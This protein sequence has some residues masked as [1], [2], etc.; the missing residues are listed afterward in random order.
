MYAIIEDKSTPTT[1][2]FKLDN[3][4]NITSIVVINIA[5][6]KEVTI[7]NPSDTNITAVY[8]D[9]GLMLIGSGGKI[10]EVKPSQ[11]FDED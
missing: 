1:D 11:L 3:E 9:D 6:K 7:S 2:A 10:Y 4:A 5:S 8:I